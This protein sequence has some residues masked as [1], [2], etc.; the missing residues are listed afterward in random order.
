M[1]ARKASH[2][3][4]EPDVSVICDPSMIFFLQNFPFVL[5]RGAGY[6]LYSS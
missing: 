3:G 6:L 1:T 2:A 5:F 4:V